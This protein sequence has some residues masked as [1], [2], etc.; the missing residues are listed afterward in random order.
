MSQPRDKQKISTWNVTAG[1]MTQRA[2]TRNGGGLWVH[3]DGRRLQ[4]RNQNKHKL[5]L[6]T[7]IEIILEHLRLKPLEVE[8]TSQVQSRRPLYSDSQ[9]E[10]KAAD[11]HAGSVLK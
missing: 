7:K 3:S 8:H 6:V 1:A 10:P 11:S 2:M 5:S 4:S 9:I